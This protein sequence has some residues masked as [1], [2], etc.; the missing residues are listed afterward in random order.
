MNIPK[1]LVVS[2]NS[3]S[4]TSNMGR[5]LGSLFMG[6]PKERIAQFCISTT[7]PDYNVCR[8]YFMIT[9][10]EALRAFVRFQKASRVLID[11]NKGT[12]GNTVIGGKKQSVRTASKSLIRN[13][14]W[15]HN[16]FASPEFDSWVDNFSPDIVLIQNSA[17]EFILKIGM[18]IAERT[19]AHVTMFNTEGYYFFDNDYLPEEH[20]FDSICFK[21]LQKSYRKTY[22][23]LMG[24]VNFAIYLNPNLAKD[25]SKEFKHDAKVLYTSSEMEFDEND[26]NTQEP[27]FSYL[28][29]FDFERHRALIEVAEVLQSLNESFRLNVYGKC[30]STEIETIIKNAPGIEF[31]GFVSYDEVKEVIKNS[32]ILFHAEVQDPIYKER[33]KYGFSTKIGDSVSS[34]HPFLMYSSPYIAGASYL[35]ETEA[36]WVAE[37]K[38]SLRFY[39][40]EI[41]TNKARRT[42]IKNKA[43]YAKENYHSSDRNRECVKQWLSDLTVNIL[44]SN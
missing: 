10:R 29:N 4:E 15:S 2:N 8:N 42:Y 5:T 18:Y 19:K 1:V 40:N 16:R 6:W 37:S 38:E 21:F 30:P 35:K 43:R 13:I 9:D 24:Y 32:T 33:L 11:E 7:E 17:S 23:K 12:E 36:G 3:F 26:V 20:W 44:N 34:G 25:Y 28:G 41:L 14:I 39:I 31:K 22:R 27:I